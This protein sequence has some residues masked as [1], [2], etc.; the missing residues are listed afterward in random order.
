MKALLLFLLLTQIM[1]PTILLGQ[2]AQPV[3]SL[4]SDLP[5]LAVCV[6][7]LS[8]ALQ[9]KGITRSVLHDTIVCLLQEGG[10]DVVDADTIQFVP[11]APTLLLHVDAILEG[12]IDQVCYSIRLEFTQTVRL[13]RDEGIIAER[14]PT[15]SMG[16]LGLYS[17]RWRDE[18][19]KDVLRHTEAF[20]DAFLAANPKL[21][22][23]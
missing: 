4:L 18:L 21:R 1:T 22:D 6:D 10:I 23:G 15:W 16:S 12:G 8:A 17:S 20:R 5:C 11:G 9:E 13:M 19:V 7:S 14:V 2:E 3:D